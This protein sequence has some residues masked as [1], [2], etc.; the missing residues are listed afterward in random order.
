M[1]SAFLWWDSANITRW[2]SLCWVFHLLKVIMVMIKICLIIVSVSFTR[3]LCWF[4][5]CVRFYYTKFIIR[6]DKFVVLSLM[7]NYRGKHVYL[8]H[9]SSVINCNS[10]FFFVKQHWRLLHTSYFLRSDVKKRQYDRSVELQSK[11]IRN[12]E[13]KLKMCCIINNLCGNTDWSVEWNFPLKPNEVFFSF[14]NCEI[15][16]QILKIHRYRCACR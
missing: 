6:N 2:I 1:Y 7:S 16:Y 15:I 9:C 13:S 10:F 3:L 8:W 11:E 12:H 4:W 14:W 5:S